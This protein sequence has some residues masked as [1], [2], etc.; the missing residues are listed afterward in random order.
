LAGLRKLDLEGTPHR[1]A[2]ILYAST[3][4]DVRPSFVVDISAQF[5]RRMRALLCYRSQYASKEEGSDL[6]PEPD[7]F[8]ERIRAAARHYGMLIHTRYGEP[9]VV[10]EMIRVEDVVRMG[11]PSF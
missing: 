8:E 6:F 9:F 3:Y 11:V 5:E 1:P 2:K 10:R 4:A 7:S